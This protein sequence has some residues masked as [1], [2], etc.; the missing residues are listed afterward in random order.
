MLAGTK[1]ND[2]RKKRTK[3]YLAHPACCVLHAVRLPVGVV[4]ALNLADAIPTADSAVAC[5]LSNAL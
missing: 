5:S 1:A 2:H 4:T 3:C